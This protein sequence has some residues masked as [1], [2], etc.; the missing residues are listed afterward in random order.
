[1]SSFNGR[2]YR[3]GAE[4]KTGVLQ[5]N[6]EYDGEMGVSSCGTAYLLAVNEAGTGFTACKQAVART[7]ATVN[8]GLASSPVLSEN[9]LTMTMWPCRNSAAFVPAYKTA[10]LRA[11][12]R[13]T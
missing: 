6:P 10:F 1:V 12:C 4:N 2:S 8:S 11:A 13:V 9:T 7:T 3:S 5:L